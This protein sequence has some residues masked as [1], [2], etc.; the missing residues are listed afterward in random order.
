MLKGKLIRSAGGLL[1]GL[2]EGL[3][4]LAEMLLGSEALSFFSML[5][6]NSISSVV[7]FMKKKI[8]GLFE[9]ICKDFDHGI[10]FSIF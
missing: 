6:F 7:G 9:V 8:Q 2:L 3:N 4:T 1:S 10:S 5:I